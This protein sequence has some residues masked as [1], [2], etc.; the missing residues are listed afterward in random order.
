[1]KKKKKKNYYFSDREEQAV[2]DFI[3]KD[4]PQNIRDRIYSDIIHPAFDKMIR[5]LIY[6]R[7]IHYTGVEKEALVSETQAHVW[8]ALTTS[9]FDPS[10]GKA[11]SYFTRT[12]L[13][14]LYQKQM[15]YQREKEKM[16]FY[17]IDDDENY[18]AETYIEEPEDFS[19]EKFLEWYKRW[20]DQH[21]DDFFD[22]E[23]EHKIA[24]A[25]YT[26]LKNDDVNIEDKRDLK[27]SIVQITGINN[28]YKINKVLDILKERY[29]KIK[30]IYAKKREFDIEKKFK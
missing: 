15:S 14:Y 30:N 13:N 11:Y 3:N 4:I 8:E 7:K 9:G 25:I 26:I 27:F 18:Y 16:G 2:A 29:F 23:D 1:M 12:V 19:V 28:N 10:Q 17:S 20:L 24:N 22:N 21:I 6:Q 5:M